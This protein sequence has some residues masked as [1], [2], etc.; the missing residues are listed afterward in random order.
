DVAEFFLEQGQLYLCKPVGGRIC[1][2]VFIGSGTF[3]FTPPTD[4]EK[5]QLARFYDVE[6]LQKDFKVLCLVFADSTFDELS[7]GLRFTEA[8]V[9]AAVNN[10]ITN[11]LEY[12]SDDEHKYFDESIVNALLNNEKNDLFYARIAE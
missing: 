3:T 6:A 10:E 12:I 8:Q 1:A 11:T 7:R 4:V 9:P 5:K 2:A